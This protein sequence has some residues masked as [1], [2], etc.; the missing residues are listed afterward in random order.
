MSWLF[1][2]FQSDGP[3]SSEQ[4]HDD[5]SPSTTPRGVKD[6]LSA[7]G[8]TL[9]RQFRGVAN[10][11]A[12]PPPPSSIAAVD[13][14]SSSS[15]LQSQSQSQSQSQ[16][17]VGIRNDLVE[18]GGSL[19]SRLSLLSSAK[20][21]SEISKLASNLLLF[22][23]NEEE[24]E[25]EEEEEAFRQDED[26]DDVPG[27]TDDVLDFVSEISTRPE[28]WTDFPLPL[29][30]N[31]FNMSDVQKEHASTVE[32]L[33][34][35]LAAL[36]LKLQS[37]MSEEQ[38]WIIYF[39]L[40]LPRLSE[41]DF[42]LL[43]TSKA[44][45]FFLYLVKI[46]Y[47]SFP[48][49]ILCKK[50]PFQTNVSLLKFV[51]LQILEARDVLLQK[52]QKNAQLENENSKTLDRSQDSSKVSKPQGENMQSDL[53]VDSTDIRRAEVAM[54]DEGNTEKWLEEEDIETGTSV[55]AQNKVEH[56][57]D[58]EEDVT[59]SDL[60]DDDNDLSN[61]LSCLSLKQQKEGHSNGCSDWV[62]LNRSPETQ[63]GHGQ[64][65][66]GQSNIQDK[67]SEGE[68]SNDWLTVDDF[69]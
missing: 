27:V 12:P 39:I 37:Y 67:D 45:I 65:K 62:Q 49:F 17:L 16:A 11:L 2:S 23:N 64:Q 13:P 29:D 66:E 28:L 40:L 8:Q 68:D 46:I 24:E 43:S 51:S 4:D 19:K 1:K 15:E 61:R 44:R 57:E 50:L 3:D 54:D 22:E 36:R 21:V 30:N 10:F 48:I 58:H 47:M 26:D 60:E 25:E 5:H 56:E 20:A 9:G 42:E 69:E 38:F 33:A 18:I 32:H 31:D 14:S 7:L 6:D 52:L 41:H 35:S 63:C 59:F 34:P 53:K 55:H